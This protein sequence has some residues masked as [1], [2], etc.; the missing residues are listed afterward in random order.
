MTFK[1]KFGRTAFLAAALALF[2]TAASEARAACSDPASPG[3]DWSGCDMP[4]ADLSG[5]HLPGANL[6]G[7]NLFYAD[8]SSANLTNANLTGATLSNAY[9]YG[10]DTTGADMTGAYL[11]GAVLSNANLTGANLTGANLTGTNLFDANLSGA[12]LSNADLTGADLDGWTGLCRWVSGGLQLTLRKNRL[13]GLPRA[14][15]TNFGQARP[16]HICAGVTRRW[17]LV[18]TRRS[19]TASSAGAGRRL[20]PD[21]SGAPRL[22]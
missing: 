8:L 6:S 20:F 14:I 13:T 17:L 19:T 5:A 1:T 2:L 15:C 18:P 9:L 16:L 11:D 12:N 7:A 10:A 4:G 3:V 21:V 22:A